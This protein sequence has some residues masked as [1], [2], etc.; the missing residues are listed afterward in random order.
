VWASL[1]DQPDLMS[2]LFRLFDRTCS[3]HKP[4]H[5]LQFIAECAKAFLWSP[6]HLN[7]LLNRVKQ[8]SPPPSLTHFYTFL[9][10]TCIFAAGAEKELN[11]FHNFPDFFSA[12]RAFL[13]SDH[14]DS[15]DWERFRTTVMDAVTLIEKLQIRDEPVHFYQSLFI[16]GEKLLGTSVRE[17]Q[18]LGTQMIVHGIK[19]RRSK[20]TVQSGWAS[21]QSQSRIGDLIIQG[22]LPPECIAELGDFVKEAMST[23]DPALLWDRAMASPPGEKASLMAILGSSLGNKNESAIGPFLDRIDAVEMSAEIVHFLGVIARSVS[24]RYRDLGDRVVKMLVRAADVEGLDD[25]VIDELRYFATADGGAW[26]RP[27]LIQQCKDKLKTSE[28]EGFAVKVLILFLEKKSAVA[29][30]G[31]PEIRRFIIA[32]PAKRQTFLPVLNAVCRSQ[33]LSLSGDEIQF[34]AA[35]DC[36]DLFWDFFARLF[37]DVGHRAVYSDEYACFD[38]LLGGID[39]SVAFVDFGPASTVREYRAGTLRKPHGRLVLQ[40]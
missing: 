40:P 25:K 30:D 14:P 23:T 5:S 7:D 13:S 26:M 22:K 31:L 3:L 9:R 12:F 17:R 16:F 27:R 32:S 1:N 28:G 15:T 11:F 38:S 19:N 39:P 33:Q 4:V 35:A 6:Q 20:P 37:R 8:T 36:D 18:W 24:V 10:L 29:I 2:T 21:W 34:L